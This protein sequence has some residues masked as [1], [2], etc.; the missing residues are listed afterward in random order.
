MSI[1][2][3]VVDVEPLEDC[4]VHPTTFPA[5]TAQIEAMRVVKQVQRAI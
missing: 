1:N 5:S 4:L 3:V 2:G